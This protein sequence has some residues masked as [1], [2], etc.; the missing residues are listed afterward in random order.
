MLVTQPQNVLVS[1]G[2][3]IATIVWFVI[4]ISETA[5]LGYHNKKNGGR[6]A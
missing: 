2:N 1:Q 3:I 6:N 5:R 4:T